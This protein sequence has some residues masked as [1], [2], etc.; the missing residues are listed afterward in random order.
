MQSSP[1]IDLHEF[2]VAEAKKYL[3]SFIAALPKGTKELEVIHG[4]NRGSTLQKF[5]RTDYKNKRVEKKILGL[6]QGSTI[7]MLK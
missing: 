5:V 2:T 4:F 6:N 1:E 3:D 7:F